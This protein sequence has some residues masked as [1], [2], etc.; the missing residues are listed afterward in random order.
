MCTYTMATP[1]TTTAI[2]Q[3]TLPLK[4]L[5]SQ[6]AST[7]ATKGMLSSLDIYTSSANKQLVR[8]GTPRKDGAESSRF[9]LQN[10]LYQEF[11]VSVTTNLYVIIGCILTMESVGKVCTPGRCQPC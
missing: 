3:M 6:N 4:R 5:P 8:R 1:T 7:S 10:D 9:S 11:C 2:V